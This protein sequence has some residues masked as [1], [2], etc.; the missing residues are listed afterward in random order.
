MSD[1]KKFLSQN[2]VKKENVFFPVSDFFLGEEGKPVLWE[3]R[4]VTTEENE[5]FAEQCTEIRT[6]DG[7]T[8]EYLSKKRHAVLLCAAAVVFPNLNN[9]ELQDSYG[10]KNAEALIL[11]MLDTP[12]EFAYLHSKVLEMNGF[13]KAFQDKVA[14]AKN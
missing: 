12:A 2:K 10:V 13:H 1:F 6:V 14:E 4:H 11:K 3:L 5:T 7:K 9:V 8:V